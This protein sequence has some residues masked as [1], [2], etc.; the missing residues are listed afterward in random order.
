MKN[1]VLPGRGDIDVV[2][3]A[4]R[5]TYN[6][7]IKSIQDASKV[8]RKHIAQVLAASDYL[9][10]SPV[11]WLPKAKEKRVVSRGGVTVFCGTARQLYSHFN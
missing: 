5:E 2:F 10:T 11:I 3:K 9:K 8:S 4:R 6:I 7:E 1:Q